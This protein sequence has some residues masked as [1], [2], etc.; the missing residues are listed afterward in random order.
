MIAHG[1]V[2]RETRNV[3]LFT[4]VDDSEA[5][6]WRRFGGPHSGRGLPPAGSAHRK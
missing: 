1:F 2:V 5:L 6:P 3:D 4:E